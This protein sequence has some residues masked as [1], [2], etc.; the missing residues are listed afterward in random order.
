MAGFIV[1]LYKTHEDYKLNYYPTVK[2]DENKKFYPI[3]LTLEEWYINFNHLIR[4]MIH[5][6][7]VEMFNA[8]SL[9]LSLLETNPYHISSC[10]VFERDIQI[11]NECGINEYFLML[12]NNT[13]QD[14]CKTFLCN[15]VYKN[16]F[17]DFIKQYK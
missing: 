2:Y 8:K 7:V 13:I 11:I 5:G 14:F 4:D 16:E 17:E 6:Y 3:V 9:N 12:Q 10:A 15:F 1:Q